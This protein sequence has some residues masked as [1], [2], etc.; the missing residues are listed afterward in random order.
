MS[1]EPKTFS[2]LRK[3]PTLNLVDDPLSVSKS[4]ALSISIYV[5]PILEISYPLTYALPCEKPNANFASL[6]TLPS[7]D[8]IP[9]AYIPRLVPANRCSLISNSKSSTV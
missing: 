3:E 7:S 9:A 1:G 8:S 5:V 6:A 2:T 4:L